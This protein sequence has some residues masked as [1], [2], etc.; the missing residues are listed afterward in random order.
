ME[1]ISH[2]QS[3]VGICSRRVARRVLEVSKRRRF[4][5]VWVELDVVGVV[6]SG[7]EMDWVERW[8]ECLWLVDWEGEICSC[9]ICCHQ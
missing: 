9:Q 7:G 5:P 8:K 4:V 1:A 3:V 2:I 6:R